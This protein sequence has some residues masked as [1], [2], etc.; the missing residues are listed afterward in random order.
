M[1]LLKNRII[2]EGKVLPGN[3]VKVDSFL[4]H[5]MDPKLLHEIGKEFFQRFN[6]KGVTKIFTIEASG[7]AVAIMAG[8]EMN[9]P[10]VFA[11]KQKSSNIGENM[12][13][14]TVKSY[15]K[16]LVSNIVVSKDYL[17]QNDKVVIID[18]FLALGQAALGLIDIIHQC[19][20]ALVGVGI[21]IEKGF[22]D[23]GKLLREKGIKVESLAIIQSLDNGKIVFK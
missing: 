23:G 20:A 16:G 15:T 9:V 13:Y 2:A 12:F 17:N 8:L 21:V 11:K 3:I 7:I 5:Q 10:V 14:S 18:D 22:Q 4:N 6:N 1:E 19:G